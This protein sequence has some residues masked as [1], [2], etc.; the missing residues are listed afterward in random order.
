[1][2]LRTP[3]LL[4]VALVVPHLGWGKDG[5]SWWDETFLQNDYWNQGKAEVNIYTAKEVRYGVPRE[6]EVRHFLVKEPWDAQKGVK[7]VGSGDFSV[8]KLNQVIVVPTGSY[9]YHQMHSTFL[10]RRNGAPI[11]FSMSSQEACGNTFK[12]GR[13]QDEKLEVKVLSYFDGEG[14]A[15]VKIPLPKGPW[16]FYDELPIRLRG[17][18][19][20]SLESPLALQVFP[21][22]VSPRTGT[23]AFVPGTLREIKRTENEV[24]FQLEIGGQQD[25]LTFSALHP[26]QLL[27]WT[28]ADGSS[29]SLKQSGLVDYW[30]R[31]KPADQLF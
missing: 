25:R 11:K 27:Q 5:G 6:T 28:R 20:R 4:S 3:L 26:Y 14:D 7:A 18:V 10:D 22:T 1:M 2:K 12:T 30:N 19:S 9:S 23:L 29:L 31:N 13:I 17:I 8:I 15:S 16:V 24:E 21:G